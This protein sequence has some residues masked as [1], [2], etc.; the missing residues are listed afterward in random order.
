M[1]MEFYIASEEHSGLLTVKEVQDWAIEQAF[2][3]NKVK[4]LNQ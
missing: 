1:L 3:K 2:D 4:Q